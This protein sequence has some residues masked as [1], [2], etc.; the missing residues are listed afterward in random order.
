MSRKLPDRAESLLSREI[1]DEYV[2]INT[3]DQTAHALDGETAIVWRASGD[4]TWPDLS[5]ERV[6]EIVDALTALGLFV[7]ATGL[8][9]RSMIKRTAI[10]GAGIGIASI[11]LP[12]ASAAASASPSVSVNPGTGPIGTSVT[13]TGSNF[14]A[15]K[16][17]TVKFNGTTVGSAALTDP[18]GNIPAGYTFT[19]PSGNGPSSYTVLVTV[20]GVSASTTFQVTPAVTISPTFGTDGSTITITSGTNFTPSSTIT[21]KFDNST[22]TTS[23]ATVS[24]DSNGAIVGTPTFTVPTGAAGS[25]HTV[26]VID[27]ALKTATATFY[28]PKITLAPSTPQPKGQTITITGGGFAAFTT[29]LTAK[30]NT[31]TTV[32]LLGVQTPQATDGVGTIKGTVTFVVPSTA[33]VGA[34]TLT[35][36]DAANNAASV[37]FTVSTPTLT[38]TPSSGPRGTS[39]TIS[40]TGYTPTS[41]S[42]TVSIAGV[43]TTAVNTAGSLSGSFTV[44]SA[45][46]VNVNVVTVTD[47]SSNVGSANFTVGAVAA[48]LSDTSPKKS[49]A[50]TE[51]ISGSSGFKP[52]A[53][54]SVS[55]TG[56]GYSVSGGPFTANGSGSINGSSF[57]LN[58]PSSMGISG[59][60]T[61]ADTFG[62]TVSVGVTSGP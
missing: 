12:E 18:S 19:V 35:V 46:V 59:T 30:L 31:T 41:G 9:R 22:R 4:G 24:T 51:T 1:G 5:D 10:V 52:G 7:P 11:I 43:Q 28:A 49:R 47:G 2:V 57:T 54:V 60:V 45:A 50:I 3:G 6:A 15:N 32:T 21:V 56:S 25:I 38:L 44:P 13:L 55:V 37:Q 23:P 33:L 26:T 61:L 42:V 40:G 17:I 39:V 36:T 62:N 14:H 20:D 58:T 8:T 27:T 16:S 34:N 53:S 48:T 29:S